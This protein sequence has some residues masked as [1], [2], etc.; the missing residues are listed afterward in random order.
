MAIAPSASNAAKSLPRNVSLKISRNSTDLKVSRMLKNQ[1]CQYGHSLTALIVC[2]GPELGDKLVPVQ[3]TDGMADISVE[4]WLVSGCRHR[5]Q[6]GVPVAS[7]QLEASI[8]RLVLNKTPAQRDK[9][10]TQVMKARQ[11]PNTIHQNMVPHLRVTLV[12]GT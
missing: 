9:T 3:S 6:D 8:L 12:A 11:D 4:W 5:P 1:V 10:R 2:Y 7:T